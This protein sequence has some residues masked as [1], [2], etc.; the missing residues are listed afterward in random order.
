MEY[1]LNL[2]KQLI[3]EKKVNENTANAYI[4]TLITLNGKKPFKNLSFLKKTEDIEKLVEPYA[5]NTKRAM[6]ASIVSVLS[7]MKDKSG[8]KKPF[9]FYSDKIKRKEEPETTIKTERQQKQNWLSWAEIQKVKEGLAVSPTTKT[10]DGTQYE[11]LLHYLVLALYTDLPPRRNLDYLE[12]YIV[13]KY[14]DSLPKDKNYLD[15]STKHFF[16]CKYK[17]AKKYGTQSIA[18]PE[19]L[20]T[21]IQSYL[22]YHHVWKVVKNRKEP[23]KLL[24]NYDGSAINSINSITRILHKIFGKT[25]RISS[26]A[27]RH[28]YITDKYGDDLK[29]REE[30]A[31]KMGHD[32]STQKEYI[33]I[34]KE[35][36]KEKKT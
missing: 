2:H 17:T 7:L 15:L 33:K 13:K 23:V 14:T 1:S 6:Y 4:K 12:M 16:F 27:L 19:Q 26:S 34:D 30:D 3:D 24:V 20:W 35:E 32:L 21:V 36:S 28:I 31:L 22:K 11:K 9:L 29:E 8:F 25:N 18:I 10:I 5:D